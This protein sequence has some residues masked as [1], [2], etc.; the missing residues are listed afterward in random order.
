MV[1]FNS[2]IVRFSRLNSSNALVVIHK[3]WFSGQ[4]NKETSD[5]M[6]L[7][8]CGNKDDALIE[9]KTGRRKRFVVARKFQIPTKF[10]E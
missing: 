10:T 4:T 9:K 3:V 7:D 5:M 8:R 1:A 6:K 2:K